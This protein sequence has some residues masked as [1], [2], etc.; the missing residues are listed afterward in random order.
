MYN[1]VFKKT[2]K[3]NVQHSTYQPILLPKTT[4]IIDLIGLCYTT[5]LKCNQNEDYRPIPQTEIYFSLTQFKIVRNHRTKLIT[6]IY[7]LIYQLI[8]INED[9]RHILQTEIYFNLKL[10]GIIAQNQL[11]VSISQCIIQMVYTILYLKVSQFNLP[12][13]FLRK[14]F[15]QHNY[16]NLSL[17]PKVKKIEIILK[18]FQNKLEGLLNRYNVMQFVAFIH[19]VDKKLYTLKT[20]HVNIQKQTRHNTKTNEKTFQKRWYL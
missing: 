7:F 8:G 11:L 9:Y 13:T 4:A 12:T 20:I 5:L 10:C 2:K 17:S 6:S 14:K 19:E 16:F 1:I 15:P 18:L 3:Q